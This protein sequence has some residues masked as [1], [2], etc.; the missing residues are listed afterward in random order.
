MQVPQAQKVGWKTFGL[1]AYRL[2]LLAVWTVLALPGVILNGPIF[3]TASIISRKKAKGIPVPE[4]R[5]IY[6]V[7]EHDMGDLQ[8]LSLLPRSRLLV[9]MC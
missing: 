3:V 1:L 2:S 6:A 9:A 8:R 5:V 4:P 7:T